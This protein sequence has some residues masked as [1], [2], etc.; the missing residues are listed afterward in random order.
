M[1]DDET[2]LEA[3]MEE[4]VLMLSQEVFAVEG[5][6]VY[7]E[8]PVVIRISKA[9]NVQQMWVWQDGVLTN[10]FAV[11]T[12]REQ[13]ETAKSGRYYFTGT[14][15]GWFKPKALI[16]KH[17]SETWEANMEFAVF[18]NG[19][20]AMHATTPDHYKELGRR[21][22]GGCVRLH[23]TNAEFIFNLVSSEG[24]GLV[25]IVNR[26][27]QVSRDSKGN[28]I[29]RIGWNTVIIVEDI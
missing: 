22:S 29:R 21:A 16:R 19:G 4:N 27:G 20:V 1:S 8:F 11:S 13:W 17:W 5:F 2:L 18:F 15:V 25:P 10:Q 9:V 23:K 6:D 12:G 28:I 3:P 14:P 26:K 24:K 7:Q